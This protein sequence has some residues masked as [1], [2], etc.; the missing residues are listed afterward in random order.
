MAEKE[1]SPK[2][3]YWLKLQER[4]F[5]QKEIKLLRKI[6]GGET[7]T[8]IYLQLLLLSLRSDGKLYFDSVG[9]SF[10]E[11][12]ALE[13]DEEIANV[14]VTL[15][16]LQKKGLAEIIT[17]D[18]L[19]M[20]QYPEMVGSESYSAERMRRARRRKERQSDTVAS[21]SDSLPSQSKHNVQACDEEKELEKELELE[22]DKDIE[23]KKKLVGQRSPDKAETIPY[24]LILDYLNE[25]TGSGFRNVEGNKKLI[26][27]RWNE[28]YTQADF[29]KV[30]DNMV[31]NW[32]GVIFSGGVAAET[33]LQPSTLFSGNFDK[34][35]NQVPKTK[36][37]N[38]Y[39]NGVDYSV[40]DELKVIVPD[41]ELDL[42]ELPF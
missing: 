20:T 29:E 15:S 41:G 31:A 8:I 21:Q 2:R 24:K 19:Y 34:Y 42:E 11:E 13:L 1:Q 9:D 36:K 28:G 22:I 38:P 37:Q 18:E 40:P 30:I 32:K 35:L 16:Y 39:D 33:Y 26:R 14:E 27:A 7:Y 17:N 6:A 25:K 3:Y 10:A 4:F 12:L 23:N 5:D